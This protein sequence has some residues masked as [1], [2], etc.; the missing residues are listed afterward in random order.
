MKRVFFL[1]LTAIIFSSCSKSDDDSKIDR[2]V[3][4]QYEGNIYKKDSGPVSTLFWI[5]LYDDNTYALATNIQHTY[6][7]QGD[8][9]LYSSEGRYTKTGNTLKLSEKATI[10][11]LDRKYPSGAERTY[12]TE[13][14]DLS[15]WFPVNY[16]INNLN[17]VSTDDH[18]TGLYVQAIKKN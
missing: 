15:S 8:K 3:T 13:I 10:V 9:Y 4:A 17:F 7:Q 16:E 18:F 11:I 1:L 5:I 2:K 12:P 14:D 6:G